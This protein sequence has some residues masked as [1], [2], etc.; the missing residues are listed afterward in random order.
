M[1]GLK[2]IALATAVAAAPFAV[3]ADMTALDDSAMGNVTGQ[4]GVT[5][6]LQTHVNIGKFTYFDEGTFNVSGIE[7]GGGAL[8]ADGTV[9]DTSNLDD[10]ALVIDVEADGDA[11]IHLTSTH[12][13]GAPVDFGMSVAEASLGGQAGENTV[14]LSN[15]GLS[16][17]L[18]QLDIRVDT[19]GDSPNTRFGVIPV[20][21]ANGVAD[22]LRVDVA[23]DIDELNV[24][25]DFLALGVR[26]MVITGAAGEAIASD[27]TK[28]APNEGAGTDFAAANLA[29]YSGE[30]VVHGAGSSALVIEM[31]I[32]PMDIS[33][34]LTLGSDGSGTALPLGSIGIDNLALTNTKAV[35]YGHN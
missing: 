9:E 17:D 24:D 4:S 30:S 21:L 25:V 16:G 28:Q 23:F 15:L 33:M 34:D 35:I 2:K 1:K 13:Q 26:N 22:V 11:F 5:I 6:E 29:I 8:A 19:T 31:D 14:L 18:A 12:P 27:G 10:F 3:Q 7:I 20:D 32:A